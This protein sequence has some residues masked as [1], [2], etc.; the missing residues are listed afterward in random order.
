MHGSELCCCQTGS[1][2]SAWSSTSPKTHKYGQV[3]SRKTHKGHQR[4][5]KCR[6]LQR[7]V[8]K[9]RASV[10]DALSCSGVSRR[11]ELDEGVKTRRVERS[12]RAHLQQVHRTEGREDS[13]QLGLTHT[14]THNIRQLLRL[15]TGCR[16]VC[17]RGY[18]GCCD[19][20]ESSQVLYPCSI[21]YCN[22]EA[23]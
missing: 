17:N 2:A 19:D 13:M 14:H 9:Q 10:C 5:R 12:V 20:S 7:Q 21:S 8:V 22:T 4:R 18:G 1:E 11:E 23:F 15:S 6:H 3:S 16:M